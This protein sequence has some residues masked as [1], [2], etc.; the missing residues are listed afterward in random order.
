MRGSLRQI[1]S[2]ASSL[3][4]NWPWAVLVLVMAAAYGPVLAELGRDWIRD[5]NYSHGFVLPFVSAYLLWR[6]RQHLATLPKRPVRLGVLPVLGAA[7]LLIVGAA[8]AE[9]FTQRV[10]FLLL[11]FA[12]V[13]YLLG[14]AWLRATAFPIGFLFFAIPLPYVLYYSLTSPLQAISASCAV[15][16]LKGIGV[17]VLAQGNILHLPNTTLEVAEACSGIR[18]IYA[19]MALGALL[20]YSMRVPFL[21]RLLVFLSTIPLSVAANA[22]RVWSTSLGAYLVGPQVTKGLPH[23]MYGLFVFSFALLLFFILR[24]GV[25]ALWHSAP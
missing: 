12:S 16:G 6:Q 8:G 7:A 11:L 2:G 15:V 24:R 22:F 18:S 14:W 4:V 25:R 17:P 1:W 9:V 10:S 3:R 23:E 5:S 13:L 21:G 19:F 20:A